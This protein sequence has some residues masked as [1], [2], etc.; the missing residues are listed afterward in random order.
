MLL[1]K[2]KLT[3]ISILLP[4]TNVLGTDRGS[5]CCRDDVAVSLDVNGKLGTT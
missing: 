2:R 3:C 1:L 5:L 4:N